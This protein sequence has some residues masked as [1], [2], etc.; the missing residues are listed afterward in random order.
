MEEGSQRGVILAPQRHHIYSLSDRQASTEAYDKEKNR[1]TEWWARIIQQLAKRK[2]ETEEEVKAGEIKHLKGVIKVA[3]NRINVLR[4]GHR[5][6]KKYPP[7]S[8]S[9]GWNGKEQSK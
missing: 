9:G 5:V 6:A 2:R 3:V 1:N 4:R 7:S 8:S